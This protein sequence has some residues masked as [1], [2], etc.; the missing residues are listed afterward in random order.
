MRIKIL[1]LQIEINCL[2]TRQR[3]TVIIKKKD[4]RLPSI[5]F[6]TIQ[7]WDSEILRFGCA[8]YNAVAL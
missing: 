2:L 1:N 8:D 6:L 4:F 5:G 3:R 7:T